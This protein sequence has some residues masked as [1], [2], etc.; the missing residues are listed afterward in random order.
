M[1]Q[2]TKHKFRELVLFK[3]DFRTII[4]MCLGAIYNVAGHYLAAHFDLPFW[5]DN[6]GTT[7]S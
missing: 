1:K 4:I 3:P 2:E 5:L 7:A 6:I